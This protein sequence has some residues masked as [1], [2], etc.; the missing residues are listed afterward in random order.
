MRIWG[1]PRHAERDPSFP[2]VVLAPQAPAGTLWTDAEL[3]IALLADVIA[4][5]RIDPDRVYLTGH[6]MGGNG[7]WYLAY[8]YPEHFA[9]IAPMSGPANPWRATR[10]RALPVRVFHGE[11]DA[12]VPLRESQEMVEALRARGGE[13]RF[14]VLAGRDH[15]ILDVYDDS[16]LYRWFLQHRR[17]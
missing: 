9:A 12:I 17:R 13:V 3:L 2:F 11:D 15:G 8:R 16:E 6:S 4:R 5:Y 7:T 14:S 1:V 10:L